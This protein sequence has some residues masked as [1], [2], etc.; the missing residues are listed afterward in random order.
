MLDTNFPLKDNTHIILQQLSI[1]P[2]KV[3][4]W[5]GS[6]QT[7]KTCPQDL[8]LECPMYFSKT[9]SLMSQFDQILQNELEK[10]GLD[11]DVKIAEEE[12]TEEEIMDLP[13]RPDEIDNLHSSNVP[14]K[15]HA[16]S[17]SS[18]RFFG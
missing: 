17:L 4:V 11:D 7:E 15:Q 12:E 16:R 14:K 5:P 3:W 13:P 18:Y 8:N 6:Y 2:V 1:K 10:M 9:V